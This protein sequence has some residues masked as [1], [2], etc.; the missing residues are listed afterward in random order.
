MG[1]TCRIVRDSNGNI[2][3]I[4]SNDGQKSNLF[5]N[6][7]SLY[8]TEKA[9]EYYALTE[10]ENFKD[11]QEVKKEDFT[12]SGQE[13]LSKL[14]ET[15]LA[16]N[17]YQMTSE[18]LENKLVE[19]G[20]EADVAKQVSQ[21]GGYYSNANSA[22]SNL[23]DKN[24][25][26][27]QGWMKALT[28]VQKNGGIKNVNQE[29]EWI[30]LEDYL[31]N[32]VKENN[33]KAGN[34]PSSVVE[35]Y[36]KS[37]Q[38]EIVDVEKKSWSEDTTDVIAKLEKK[39]NITITIDENPMDGSPMLDLGGEGIDDLS[40]DELTDLENEIKDEL[41]TR[42]EFEDYTKYANYQLKGASNYRE[43]LL[44]MP[45]K[46]G[47]NPLHTKRDQLSKQYREAFDSGNYDLANEIDN[48]ISDITKQLKAENSLNTTG[49]KAQYKSSHW[50][51]ANILAHVRLNEKT[52]PDGRR[53]LIVNEIQA[54]ISQD[55]KKEQE[56]IL[57]R[58]D[59]EFDN[60]L[61]NLIRKNVI[62][63]EC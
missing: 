30:G 11:V 3:Y 49:E 43:I 26:N 6:L 12:F 41:F 35:D 24:V 7:R 22:F 21:P 10:S 16:D 1:I 50:D 57:D 25:K 62:V 29:L 27:I 55:L 8:G 15:G 47:K 53:V 42:P 36:I 23:K 37:N 28:D 18:G 48:Q 2:D 61:D 14:E 34:I 56:K 31:N 19:L 44:T 13:T 32:Y 52:L 39:H 51:E 17:I 38:I 33:P 5:D 40:D 9:L 63:E 58:V 54:D 60:F 20:V 59:K 4:E 45:S 46:E